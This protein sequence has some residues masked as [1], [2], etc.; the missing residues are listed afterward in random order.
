MLF[1]NFKTESDDA[2]TPIS[3]SQQ[4]ISYINMI[5]EYIK[6]SVNNQY[7]E[8]SSWI[9]PTCFPT[10]TDVS[11]IPIPLQYGIIAV[12]GFYKNPLTNGAIGS[13]PLYEAGNHQSHIYICQ[14]VYIAIYIYRYILLYLISHP[15]SNHI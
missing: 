15:H 4:S 13:H 12:Y 14:Y 8:E 9:P 7:G 2:T 6:I 3:P 11:T 5:T 1:L 10:S